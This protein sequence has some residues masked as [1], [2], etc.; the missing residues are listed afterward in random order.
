MFYKRFFLNYSYPFYIYL[1]IMPIYYHHN[2]SYQYQVQYYFRIGLLGLNYI[3][4][5]S[6][7]IPVPYLL[8]TWE[9]SGTVSKAGLKHSAK[10]WFSI[11]RNFRQF[12]SSPKA[13][14]GESIQIHYQNRYQALCEHLNRWET[15][16][17]WHKKL[18]SMPFK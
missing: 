8:I 18:T 12:V 7:I 10:P 15:I 9:Y 13:I 16:N 4:Y 3:R 14:S 11:A 1:S 17:S 2:L 5:P 6:C